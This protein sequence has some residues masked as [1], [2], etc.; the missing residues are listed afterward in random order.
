[1]EPLLDHRLSIGTRNAHDR[2][3]E[4]ITM[5][6]CQALESLQRVDHLEEVGLRIIGGISLRNLGNYE[7]S[8]TT[9]IQ[10][11]NIVVTVITL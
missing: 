3:V 6:F 2:N 7:I 5:T 10:L 4:L 8:N 1:M 11:W 9:A